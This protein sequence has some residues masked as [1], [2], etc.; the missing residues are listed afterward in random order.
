MTGLLPTTR[1]AAHYDN[2]KSKRGGRLAKLFVLY[3]RRYP[4]LRLCSSTGILTVVGI[5][6]LIY[7]VA[8][9][10]GPGSPVSSQKQV[11]LISA[12][13][14]RLRGSPI[15]S[16]EGQT[17]EGTGDEAK[18]G[19][20]NNDSGDDTGENLEKSKGSHRGSRS[21]E[22]G[23]NYDE[24]GLEVKANAEGGSTLGLTEPLVDDFDVNT[25]DTKRKAIQ[26]KMDAESRQFDKK[27]VDG[28]SGDL[29][30]LI[31]ENT[32]MEEKRKNNVIM[33]IEQE[34]YERGNMLVNKQKNE[35]LV[36]GVKKLDK[37]AQ[38]GEG[39]GKQQD[40]SDFQEDRENVDEHKS[41]QGQKNGVGGSNSDE[42]ETPEEEALREVQMDN[43][44]R[45]RQGLGSGDSQGGGDKTSE[46]GT[47]G[48]NVQKHL[49]LPNRDELVIGNRLTDVGL[50]AGYVKANVSSV[51]HL[52]DPHTV[53]HR[54][55]AARNHRLETKSHDD[56]NGSKVGV[57]NPPEKGGRDREQHQGGKLKKKVNNIGERE[58]MGFQ[59]DKEKNAEPKAVAGETEQKSKGEKAERA[60]TNSPNSKW[61]TQQEA[62]VAAFRHA[63]TG[64]RSYSMGFDELKPVSRR[65]ENNL[66]GLGATVIDA[67]DT[68]I[69]MGQKDIVEEAGNW[70]KVEL[71][72][73][74]ASANQVNL[75]ETTIRVLGGL[76]SAY[77]L[78]GGGKGGVVDG[79]EHRWGPPPEVY[80][81]CAKDLG[82]R[83]FEA[84]RQSPTAIPLSDVVLSTKSS[85]R[86]KFNGGASSTAECTTVQL[87][88]LALSHETGD[89]QYG[90]GVMKTMELMQQLPK[91]HGLVPIF[92]DPQTGN[93]QGSEIRLGSRGDSYYEYLIKVWL[94]QNRSPQFLRD[95]YDEAMTGVKNFLVAKSVPNGLVFIGELLGGEGSALHPKMDHLVCFL[96]GTLALGATGGLSIKE[97]EIHHP[98]SKTA[99]EDLQLARDLTST[100]YQ[101]YNVTATGLAPEI[102]YFSLQNNEGRDH[103]TRADAE[104]RSD[105]E[106]HSLD[107]HN[108]LRPETVESLFYMF[109]TTGDVK[110]REWGWQIFLAFE[111]YTRVETGGYSS[112]NDVTHIP[113]PLRDSMETFFLG[114]TLKY[115]YLLFDDTNL[116]P[117]DKFVFNTEAHPLPIFPLKAEI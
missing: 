115:F 77:Y 40:V 43:E 6:F 12:R 86:A 67:L 3:Q 17:N 33:E 51:N 29:R 15:R 111:K 49:N 21:Q 81:E 31:E 22:N 41:K 53:E 45:W 96:G 54:V 101:T 71:R 116:L 109:R 99:K 5:C 25:G 94:Q 61:K 19:G 46:L 66:G 73:R 1:A 63:W 38:I 117:L 55:V 20:A 32:A 13:V 18:S 47:L 39:Q 44:G 83:L 57:I 100:C 104:Y 74:I 2:A 26:M 107:R 50:D 23:D 8:D 52:R 114:E 76:L 91:Y 11:N 62:V 88:F 95:L 10:R 58:H 59:D 64:Y 4:V 7:L 90:N 113:P 97:A 80:L 60:G 72:K 14:S 110:Y 42:T 105:I 24:N 9:W 65:G 70:V 16:N 85:E 78:S 102:T 108:L 28:V 69:I 106:I 48:Q 89:E 82:D 56:L 36:V 87:E 30:S 93:F 79:W 112:L 75:F 92:I 84:F 27:P 68:A 98:L 35:D 34:D 103:G 37:D